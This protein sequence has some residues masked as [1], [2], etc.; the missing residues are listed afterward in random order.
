MQQRNEKKLYINT[1]SYRH[2]PDG[3]TVEIDKLNIPDNVEYLGGVASVFFELIFRVRFAWISIL[4]IIKKSNPSSYSSVGIMRQMYEFDDIVP[5]NKI[6]ILRGFYQNHNYID[7]I[8]ANKLREWYKT[9]N[10]LSDE[11]NALIEKLMS[12]NS[13]CVHIRRGDYVTN[14]V[15]SKGLN[16][17]DENYYV[18]A[19]ECIKKQVQNPV[20]YCFTNDE[21]DAQW[22]RD[23]YNLPC[24]LK[25]I[26][27]NRTDL[28]EL[29]IMRAC[30]HFVL[31]NSTF[32]W[33]AAYLSDNEAKTV[34]M[35]GKWNKDVDGF[36]GMYPVNWQKI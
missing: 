23:N 13:V 20:F 3:R 12:E 33:W 27:I 4:N 16:I 28:E 8:D 7:D 26:D 24:D 32:G 21:S 10:N 29:Q 18:N 22:I 1:L 11:Q 2:E 30:R 36:E 31:S 34:M 6:C 9:R 5:K 25:F 14:P 17:C 15:W 35:P 19:I